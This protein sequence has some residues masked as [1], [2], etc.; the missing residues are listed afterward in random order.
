MFK[1][2]CHQC[3][4][5]FDST[6]RN[7]KY[8][9]AE[10]AGKAKERHNKLHNNRREYARDA[11]RR[12]KLTMSR[13]EAREFAISLL[14]TVCVGCGKVVAIKNIEIHHRDGDPFNNVPENLAPLCGQ[15]HPKEDVIWRK[16][17]EEGNP[18]PDCRRFKPSIVSETL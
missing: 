8:C 13:A 16:A 12:R 5:P 11:P 7:T 9:S 6:A 14:P 1:K 18:I 3:K 4:N 15:C 17:K 10:C 2:N